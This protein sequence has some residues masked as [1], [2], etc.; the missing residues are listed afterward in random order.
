MKRTKVLG[1]GKAIPPRV[2][3]N[4]ELSKYMDTSDEWIVQR[5]GIKTRHWVAPEVSTSDLA[6]EAAQDALKKTGVKAEE[7]D[8]IVLAT[9]SPDHEFPGTAHYLQAKLGVSGMPAIDVRQQCTGFIFG[10]SIIDQ[11]I[12]NGAVKKALLVGSETHSKGLD[13]STRGREVS[14]LFGDGAGALVLGAT[15]VNSPADSQLFASVL[16]S[17]GSFADELSVQA[18][19]HAYP[20]E[21]LNAALLEANAHYPKMNGKLVFQHATRRMPE[22]TIEALTQSGFEIPD[23]DLFLFHQANLRINEFAAKQLGADSGKVFNTIERF[24]NTSAATIPI[25][26]ATALEEGRLKPGMIVATAG[27]GSGFSWGGAVLRW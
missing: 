4:D 23:V 5:S 10:L 17:D 12:R 2:V 11:F 22:V 8:M 1:V 27:F 9:L 19:G 16:H 14:V 24:G 26:M 21:R 3:T 15:E 18:P 6:F 7:L 20:K 13:I 25:G